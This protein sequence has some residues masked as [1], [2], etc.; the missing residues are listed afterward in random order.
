MLFIMRT[1]I[2]HFDRLANQMRRVAAA[3]CISLSTLISR[4]LSDALKRREPLEPE[5]FR[6]LTVR[7]VSSRPGVDLDRPRAFEAEDD[8]TRFK[9]LQR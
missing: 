5:P 6:L 1:A 7:S 2:S 9:N 8:E 3:R 4:M